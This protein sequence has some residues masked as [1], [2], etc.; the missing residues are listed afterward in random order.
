M[1]MHTCRL[2][3]PSLFPNPLPSS[4]AGRA[5][6]SVFH[7]FYDVF[8]PF[9]LWLVL[10]CPNSNIGITPQHT[11]THDVVEPT[12]PQ[13]AAAVPARPAV[14]QLHVRDGAVGHGP[15]GPQARQNRVLGLH[16][17]HPARP[18][19]GAPPPVTA[20]TAAVTAAAGVH[21]DQT[22]RVQ[23]RD[24]LRRG[25]RE[26]LPWRRDARRG[27]EPGGARASTSF[28]TISHGFLSPVPSL[29][30]CAACSF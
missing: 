15:R 20:G 9:P 13:A 21:G 26:P 7:S 1:V 28:W 16:H 14:L 11:T 5:R 17:R 12:H 27:R 6:P 10:L 19:G 4:S 29:T 24:R 22:L 8:D 3:A 23:A 2:L 25:R 30:R 18:L